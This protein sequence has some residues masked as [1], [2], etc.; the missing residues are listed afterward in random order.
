MQTHTH[1][2]RQTH[3]QIDTQTDRHT[4]KQTHKQ[5]DTQTDRHMECTVEDDGLRH[6]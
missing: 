3:R 4:D 5:I 1:I 6:R 2:D